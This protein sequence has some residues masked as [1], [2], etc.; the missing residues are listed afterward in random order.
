VTEPRHA[1]GVASVQGTR[2]PRLILLRHAQTTAQRGVL[3][4]CRADPGLS[5]DGR[6]CARKAGE[7]LGRHRIDAVLCSPLRRARETAELAFPGMAPYVDERLVEQDFGE[8]TGL[9]WEEAKQ[10][11]GDRARAWRD[12]RAAAPGGESAFALVARVRAAA[13]EANRHARAGRVVLVTHHTPIRALIALSRGW[14]PADW[15]RITVG[16]GQ[17]R[18]VRSDG[19]SAVAH[20]RP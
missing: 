7:R 3:L 16:H 19:E 14:C 11:F 15:R 20:A 17:I 4:G 1:A 18:L 5:D 6:D 8:L 10:G 12:G 9:T 2:E 13:S